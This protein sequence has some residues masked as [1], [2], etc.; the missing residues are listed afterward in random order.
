MEKYR[1]GDNFISESPSC[2]DSKILI[3]PLDGDPF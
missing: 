1:V 3:N 2:F